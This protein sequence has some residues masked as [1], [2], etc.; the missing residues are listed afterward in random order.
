MIAEDHFES[1]DHAKQS[2]RVWLRLVS[3]SR[4]IESRIRRNFEVH[5]NTTLP[6]FDVLAA[7]DHAKSITDKGLTMGE[8]SK[9]L[10]VSNGNVTGI[11]ERLS[12]DKYI[13][14]TKQKSDGRSH[15]VELTSKGKEYFA[16]LASAHESWIDEMLSELSEQDMDNVLPTLS[17]L[18]STLSDSNPSGEE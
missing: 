9:R 3:C 4:I 2:L 11:V 13:R 18:K 14:K 8:L 6:R 7:L 5:F 15:V 17:K 10:L 12:T 16:T 1:N